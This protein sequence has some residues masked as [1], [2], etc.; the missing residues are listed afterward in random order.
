MDGTFHLKLE[1]TM[2]KKKWI[3]SLAVTL[4]SFSSFAQDNLTFLHYNLLFYGKYAYDCNPT[5]N[6]I[7][8]KTE[9]LKTIL[10]HTRPDVFTVNE[11]DGEGAEPEVEDADYLLNNAL[12]VD[13]TAHYRKAPFEEDY[14]VNTL[15]YNSSKLTLYDHYSIAIQTGLGK[16]F[17]GYT[18][19][20]NSNDLATSNDTTFFTCFVVHLKAGSGLDDQQQRNQEVQE[21]MDYIQQ[22]K[23]GRGNYILAGDFNVYT[24]EEDA[25]QGLINPSDELYRFWD[26]VDQPGEWHSNS[27]YVSYHTQSTHV[28]GDCFSGGGMDDRFDFI[29]LSQDVMNGEQGVSYIQDSYQTVGQDGSFFNQAMEIQSNGSVSQEV[30]EAL[31]GFSDHLPVSLQVRVSSDPATE[32]DFDTVYH[33]PQTPGMEDGVEVFAQVSDT[34]G[35]IAHIRALWGE[36]TGQYP[37]DTGMVLDGNYYQTMLPP[38]DAGQTVYFRVKG[39]DSEDQVI[40]S[41]R[42]YSYTVDESDVTGFDPGERSRGL[43]VVHPVD[44]QLII[45]LDENTKGEYLV[46]IGD[47]T[48]RVLISESM[49]LYGTDRITMPVG[50]LD[51]GVYWVRIH[52][53]QTW[54]VEK[55]IK[56]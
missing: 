45:H 10:A 51:P 7:V 44:Q 17:N 13:G 22:E 1:K 11:L 33:E 26:P 28:S 27:D 3:I 42:E 23:P 43:E 54:S 34:E 47:M 50:S 21:L 53:G 56:N 46:E 5:N 41:S 15:F 8:N 49:D 39:Y 4:L 24:S 40:L 9:D 48:G 32:L 2:K 19:Y 37:Q 55:F 25:Y 29:L 35:Q 6:D 52:D 30:A 16:H 36:Q 18:F 14:S 20:Y 12:N 38:H 31:Y